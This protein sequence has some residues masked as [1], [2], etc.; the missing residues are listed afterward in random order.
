MSH[1]IALSHYSINSVMNKTN[2]ISMPAPSKGRAIIYWIATV[3]IGVETI[4]G[5]YW[6]IAQID[7]VK[8]VFERLGYPLYFL[9]FMGIWKVFGAIVLFIPGYPRLKEWVYAGLIFTYT[10]AAFSHLAEGEIPETISPVILAGL[11]L[12][13]WALRPASR[14]N[15]AR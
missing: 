10:G 1:L 8:D 2:Q 14:R 5:A 4:V 3:L 11:T 12:V 7:Y 9:T 6:D 13:S 15:F